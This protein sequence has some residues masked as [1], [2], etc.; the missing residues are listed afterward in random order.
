MVLWFVVCGLW[1]CGLWFVVFVVCGLCVFKTAQNT[2]V[3]CN[4]TRGVEQYDRES[5]EQ[6]LRQQPLR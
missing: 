1:L 5:I 6:T 3:L 4:T 2:P